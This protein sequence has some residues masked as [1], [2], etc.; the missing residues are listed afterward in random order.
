MVID[1]IMVISK[2]ASERI[3]ERFYNLVDNDFLESKVSDVDAGTFELLINTCS[4]EARKQLLKGYREIKSFDNLGVCGVVNKG[5]LELITVF[6]HENKAIKRIDSSNEYGLKTLTLKARQ[7]QEMAKTK[8]KNKAVGAEMNRVCRK[9]SALKEVIGA[10][11]K[12]RTRTHIEKIEA[13]LAELK[14]FAI[15]KL[16]KDVVYEFIDS[17]RLE[18]KGDK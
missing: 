1:Y 6:P 15:S 8:R 14:R 9:L 13:E 17:L 4:I 3:G 16:G 2:H 5:T 18:T 7:M 11:D 10:D 12:S